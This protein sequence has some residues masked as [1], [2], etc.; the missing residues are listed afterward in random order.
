MKKFICATLL[1]VSFQGFTLA[2]ASEQGDSMQV[3]VQLLE[4]ALASKSSKQVLDAWCHAL[5]ER[6]GA[7]QYAYLSDELRAK[8]YF[9]MED[10]NWVTG[11]SSP[12]IEQVSI[13]KEKKINDYQVEYDLDIGITDSAK[14]RKVEHAKVIVKLEGEKWVVSQIAV[15]PI[16][17]KS[18][19][20]RTP[21]IE[22]EFRPYLY[23]EEDYILALPSSWK[24]KL[25]I[26]RD[27]ENRRTGF[28]Y[29]PGD[30]TKEDAAFFGIERIPVKDWQEWGEETGMHTY[31]GEHNGIVYA[32]VKASENPYAKDQ[33]QPEYEE[34]QHM[35]LQVSD[36]VHSFYLK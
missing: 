34:F 36:I 12:W 23:E 25:K 22:G 10:L 8:Y 31:L 21:Y 14:V 17:S 28:I 20:V 4:Q 29:Q 30:S 19:S 6:N 24:G 18:I 2:S 5:K 15:N 26:S 11:G 33:S 9:V 27:K 13:K 1:L 35:L 3:R 7:V 16:E 32:L